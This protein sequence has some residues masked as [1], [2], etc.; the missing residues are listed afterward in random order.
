MPLNTI[1][2]VVWCQRNVNT[3]ED[4]NAQLALLINKT[5]LSIWAHQHTNLSVT[6]NAATTLD[7]KLKSCHAVIILG[8]YYFLG[9]NQDLD[10]LI[11]I[12][13]GIE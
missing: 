5:S 11:R 7:L 4:Q 8:K 1:I 13:Y 10:Y 9:C 6:L 12:S 2:E 3:R